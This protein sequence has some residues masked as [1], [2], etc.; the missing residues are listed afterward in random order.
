MMMMTKMNQTKG[1]QKPQ[2]RWLVRQQQ[3][4][5]KRQPK[6]N[7]FD[8]EMNNKLLKISVCAD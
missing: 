8:K 6:E 5:P 2:S 4:Q 7:L 3:R 1:P